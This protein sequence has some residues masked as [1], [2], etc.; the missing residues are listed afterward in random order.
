MLLEEQARNLHPHDGRDQPA[1]L[2]GFCECMDRIGVN[3][4]LRPGNYCSWSWKS[5]T[6]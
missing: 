6:P 4:P 2:E 3:A 1:E 5:P